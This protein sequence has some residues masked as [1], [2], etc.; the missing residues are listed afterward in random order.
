MNRYGRERQ[1]I[2]VRIAKPM[3]HSDDGIHRPEG[4][5]GIEYPLNKKSCGVGYVELF[6]ECRRR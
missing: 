5:D 1:K 4:K 3:V 2:G 6:K